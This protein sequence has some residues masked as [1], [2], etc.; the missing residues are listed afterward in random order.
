MELLIVILLIVI[1]IVWMRGLYKIYRSKSKPYGTIFSLFG[2]LL[3]RMYDNYSVG[4]M[5]IPLSTEDIAEWFYNDIH[6][7]ESMAWL[8]LLVSPFVYSFLESCKK[9]GSFQLEPI[10]KNLVSKDTAYKMIDVAVSTR[11]DG[12]TVY[13]KQKQYYDVSFYSVSMKCKE[14]G[15]QWKKQER[16]EELL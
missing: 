4:G 10:D 1:I 14:C 3:W 9:C 16:V 13:E 8:V 6:W 2:L 7:S 12:T 15:Y 5:L 11:T